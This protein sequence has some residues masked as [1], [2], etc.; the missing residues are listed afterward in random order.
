MNH[1]FWGLVIEGE[2][3]H[4]VSPLHQELDT[5]KVTKAL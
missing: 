1:R 2:P 4:A 5:F 3:D